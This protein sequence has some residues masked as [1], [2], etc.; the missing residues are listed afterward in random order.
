MLW[1]RWLPWRF[2]VRR[3]AK[4][5]GF[6]DP[7]AL[8][9]K[10]QSL[11]Q[12][13]E[14]AVPT[15]L[16]RAGV[17]MH[18]RGLI[19]SRVIQH[20]LDWVW[21]FWVQRQFDPQDGSFVPRAFSITH[22]NLTHR[23]WTAVG[24]PD[25]DALP[26]V[27]PAGMVT[28]RYD[29]WSLDAWLMADDG[30]MLVPSRIKDP[31]QRLDV[32]DGPVVTTETGSGGLYLTTRADVSDGRDTGEGPACRYRVRAQ[33][34]GS[35][36]LALALR[37]YN[38]EGISLV[39]RIALND[40]RRG[41]RADH[42]PPV[43]F[44]RPAQRHHASDYFSGD[45]FIHLTDRAD[46]SGATCDV[47]LAT[48]AAMFRLERD[49]PL[50]VTA[51]VPLE[52]EGP[53]GK[54]VSVRVPPQP[55]GD[56]LSG[57]AKVEVPDPHFRFLYDAAVRSLVLHAPGD[58]YPGP[59]TYKRFWFRD[60]AFIIDALLTAGLVDRAERALDR[61]P[62]LQTPTGYYRSQEGEWDS[63]GAALWAIDRFHRLTGRPVKEAWRS[64]IVRGARWIERKRKGTLGIANKFDGLFPAGFSAEHLGPNDY[65][66]WDDFFGVA[67][68]RAAAALT[69]SWGDTDHA[70][71]FAAGA[72]DFRRAIDRTL[73]DAA[74]RLGRPAMPAAPDRRL[75]AGAI[76]SI[77]AS[78]PLALV[79]PDDPR[80]VDL[81]T[82]LMD[83]HFFEGAFFQDMIH[84]GCNAYLTL[85][86]AQALLR[87]GDPRFFDCVRR[88]AEI[89]SPTGQWP[90][91]IHPR[92]GGGCMGDGHHVWAAAE[93]V[94]MLRNMFV[95]EEEGRLILASGLP[96][97]WL[98]AAAP[99]R[100]GPTPTAWGPVEVEVRAEG[101]QVTVAWTGDW[102]G[103]PPT[104]EVHLAG[105][106]PVAA[107]EGQ[108]R[109]A[110]SRGAS[111]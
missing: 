105:L 108:T 102:R 80:V 109:L 55:W 45:V 35:G 92:T 81:A 93:W 36:W 106:A 85:H 94:M 31:D 95:R 51:R 40:D 73:R 110:L 72:E 17:F 21:P 28:P 62:D 46:D 8:M 56:A 1:T 83:Q 75:D 53:E 71:T 18:A 23:N 44:D 67:G 39:H 97:E 6:L 34:D 41:W 90:E 48:A 65:Y 104:V 103:D 61:F 19:N 9:N 68:L 10:L 70:E 52:A 87:A 111:A 13:S 66:Y 16:L 98:T 54:G 2:V 14:V 43:R 42:G 27:D 49:V 107:A 37:P 99:L 33:A 77:A 20:N 88:V 89:A 22:I 74:R 12:P 69:R 5:H 15:E 63:N 4:A 58:V 84:S 11:T 47:G 3:V 7:I 38:P 96:A 78:Y 64:S 101:E 82:Y 60:A 57:T 24:L 32:T 86:V 100:F 59:F 30:R 26:V 91:A 25:L 76:G 50:E 79:A 29:G